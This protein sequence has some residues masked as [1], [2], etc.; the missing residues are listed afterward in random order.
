MRC[1][2]R[3]I[4]AA[5]ALALPAGAPAQALRCNVPARIAMPRAEGPTP[6]DPRRIMPIESYTLALIWAPE[7]C[8]G[9]SQNIDAGFA[10]GGGNRFGFVLH[11]LWPDGANG[12]WPQYCRPAPV[13]PETLIRRHLC[14][15]PSAQLLQ[16]E[17]SKHGTCMGVT[18]AAYFG[19]AS[20]L[21]AR[22][23]YP[24]MRALAARRNL[25]ARQFAAAFARANPGL[26]ADMIRLNVN[27][28]GWLEE[29]WICLDTRF[30]WRACPATQGGAAATRRIRLQ[31]PMDRR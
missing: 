3:L 16:H 18:P 8:R 25:T 9:G 31:P 27:R 21:Y 17:Y 5:L 4:L 20:R 12:S 23:R 14:T 22:L 6:R 10:C 26:T 28:R 24:D 11:G 19:Q 7:A 30:A 29:V 15:T 2:R 1:S 13:L